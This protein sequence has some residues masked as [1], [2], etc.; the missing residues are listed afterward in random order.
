MKWYNRNV[1]DITTATAGLTLAEMGAYDRLLDHYYATEEGYPMAYAETTYRICGAMTPEERVV[2]DN[3]LVRFF[4]QVDGVWR[5]K[6]CDSEIAKYNEV[7]EK[8][9]E[10]G[11]Y[12]QRVAAA[13]AKVV[14]P[15]YA[16]AYAPGDGVGQGTP[17]ARVQEPR[18]NT[19]VNPPT[20]QPEQAPVDVLGMRRQAAN[21]A[22]R[23]II[24]YLNEKA[25]FHYAHSKVHTR[26]IVARIMAGATEE[27]CK[28]VIDMKILDWG[29]DPEKRKYLSAD[30]LFNE[31]KFAKYCGQLQR[32]QT[33]Y[34][35]RKTVIV[36]AYEEENS[37][38]RSIT[39]YQ[40]PKDSMNLEQAARAAVKAHFRA[41]T[42]MRAKYVGLNVDGIEKLRLSVAEISPVPQASATT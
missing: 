27:M 38:G 10:G 14:A 7:I 26:L 22:S 3:I 34:D 40:L 41:L 9:R 37:L 6:K 29:T 8:K 32:S 13:R 36:M 4:H 5:N 20:P 17:R 15:G 39:S 33:K 28:E 12:G 25:G 35:K 24:N 18:T 30:T 1:G 42:L 19:E 2:V 31:T 21:E 23:R 16:A 11:L